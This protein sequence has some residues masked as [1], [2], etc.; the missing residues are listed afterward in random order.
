MVAVGAVAAGAAVD[1][2]YSTRLREG[3]AAF[4]RGSYREA[5]ESLRMACFGLLDEGPVLI[6]CLVRLGLARLESG[7]VE[8]FRE[9]FQKVVEAEELLGLYR[10]ADLPADLRERFERQ[11]KARIP[12]AV[13]A[14]TP[15]FEHLTPGGKP[16]PGVTP[17][18][19]S[20]GAPPSAAVAE[21]ESSEPTAQA[22]LSADDRRR[23]AE[24]RDAL[25]EARVVED[26]DR[27]ARLVNEV[28]SRRPGE[29]EAEL[30]AGEIAYR[31]S[32]WEE[33]V[34]HFE[35]AGDPGIE[36]CNVLFYYAV[37]LYE[38]GRPDDAA[39]Q[40]RRCT[41]R[42]DSTA[43]VERYRSLILGGGPVSG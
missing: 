36:R 35:A 6:D 24:A 8:G 25:S 16:A 27:A 11:V 4:E 9:A 22:P 18:S 20:A 7:D 21:P 34:R 39:A 19:P 10:K 38:S 5:A 26:L 42:L 43:F 13:L 17:E 1:P 31:G 29:P 15:G 33:A 28:L 32:R 41:G 2:F 30:L 12:E 40:M 3:T 23:L 14:E 37:A